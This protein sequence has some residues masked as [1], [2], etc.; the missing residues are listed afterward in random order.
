MGFGEEK[1]AEASLLHQLEDDKVPHLVA[2]DAVALLDIRFAEGWKMFAVVVVVLRVEVR[3]RA[4]VA[5]VDLDGD[6]LEEA[7]ER[8]EATTNSDARPAARV[9]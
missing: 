8:A 9:G 4:A 2:A 1:I 3:R 6:R 5:V 7:P